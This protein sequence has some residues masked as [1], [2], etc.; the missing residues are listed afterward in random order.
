MGLSI[1]LGGPPLLAAMLMPSAPLAFVMLALAFPMLTMHGVG[2]VALQL[3]TPNEYLARVTEL[4][5]FVVNLTG[6]GFGPRP[7]AL[8]TAN[9]FYVTGPLRYP[10]ALVTGGTRTPAAGF[11]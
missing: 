9:F 2:T 8:P 1:L 5:F 7:Q 6:L 3:I 11:A 4:Y 10:Q